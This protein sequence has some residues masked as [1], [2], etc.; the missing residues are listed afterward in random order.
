MILF[1]PAKINIGLNIVSKRTDGYHE[2]ESC[3]ISIPLFD[4]IE[5]QPSKELK[6]MQSGLK[7]DSSI[8]D[9][10]CI[11][12]FR[13]LQTKYAIPNVTIHLRKQIP[14]GAGLGG[15]SADAAY[16]L[17]GLNK[18]FNLNISDQELANLAATLGS[19]CPFFI[20]DSAQMATGRGEIL[21]SIALDLNGYHL[22][23][24]KPTIHINT[25]EAY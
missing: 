19:D 6:W 13:L 7:I 23:V 22:V 17:K 16:V 10:L 20:F 4:I 11:K 9:N 24:I 5:I 18:L 15:G 21:K 8:D 12:A 25:K 2:L 1:P 3:M 14:M